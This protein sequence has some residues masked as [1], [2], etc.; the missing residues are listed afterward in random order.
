MALASPAPPGAG[1]VMWWAS[2]D[3]ATTHEENS[4]QRLLTVTVSSRRSD[5]VRVARRCHDREMITLPTVTNG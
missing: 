4:Y 1:V 5:V 3:A 2:H